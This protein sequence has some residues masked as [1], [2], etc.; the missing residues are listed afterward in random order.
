MSVS[1]ITKFTV[2]VYAVIINENDEV[3]LSDEYQ[4]NM[5][6]TKFPGGG[7]EFGEGVKETLE[8][9]SMEEFSQELEVLEHFYTTDFFQQAMFLKEYQ[10]ISLYYKARFKQP[11][12]FKTTKKRFDFPQLVNETICFRWQSIND[13]DIEEVTFPIDK[14]VAKMIKSTVY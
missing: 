13:W 2:R 4:H 9:E 1:E 8:R 14:K 5:K 12:R 10:V 11:I 3:L 6:M 7:M